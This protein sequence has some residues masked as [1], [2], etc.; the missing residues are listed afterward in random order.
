M[1][2]SD[3]VEALIRCFD[4]GNKV[5]IFGCG[6]LASTANHF[7]AELVGKVT[8]QR[9][10]LPAISLSADN[11]VITSLANDL[12]FE[13]VFS[14]QIEA[15]GKSGDVAIGMST[16]GKSKSII[17]GLEQAEKQGLTVIDWPRFI[18]S[19]PEIQN[20]QTILMHDIAQAVENYFYDKNYDLGR[21]VL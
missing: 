1:T 21:V 8:L 10:A 5:L 13:F 2:K 11:A 19:T 7:S 18:G 14:R 16:S 6:G 3:I 17:N 20:N 9:K 4:S 12:G 15:L